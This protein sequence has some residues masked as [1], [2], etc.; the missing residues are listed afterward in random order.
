MLKQLFTITFFSTGLFLISG[1]LGVSTTKSICDFG[2]RQDL[3][4]EGEQSIT[5][6]S[7]NLNNT[8]TQVTRSIERLKEGTYKIVDTI[9]ND[10]TLVLET[11]IVN[12]NDKNYNLASVSRF[13]SDEDQKNSDQPETYT[14][15][16]FLISGDKVEIPFQSFYGV[17][18]EKNHIKYQNTDGLYVVDNLLK[19]TSDK[20]IEMI[21]SSNNPVKQTFSFPKK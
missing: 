16:K 15:S 9:G 20:I 11:C 6:S 21:Y 1:C 3:L 12:V 13:V 8:P 18:F 14:I 5:L 10:D 17:D 19:E 2:T 7:E 4:K